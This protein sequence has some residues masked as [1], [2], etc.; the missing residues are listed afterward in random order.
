MNAKVPIAEWA[1]DTDNRASTGVTHWP[2]GAGVKSAGV[3]RAL[4]VS[5]RGAELVN[6]QD[7]REI[8]HLPVSVDMAARSFVV[9]VPRSTL[10]VSG[11][12]RVRLAAGLADRSGQL[13]A[14]V[15]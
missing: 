10:P 5:S 4:V 6:A 8:A 14:P 15:P 13:F 11:A 3:D 2:A 7:G 9:R 1:L 12:W